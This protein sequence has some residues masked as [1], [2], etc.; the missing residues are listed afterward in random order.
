[1]S[2][3]EGWL[4]FRSTLEEALKQVWKSLEVMGVFEEVSKVV[5]LWH[6]E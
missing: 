6:F 5:P 3:L 1:M 4:S 2:M